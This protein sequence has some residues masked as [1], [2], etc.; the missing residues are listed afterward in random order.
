MRYHGPIMP[1]TGNRSSSPGSGCFA[2]SAHIHYPLDLTQAKRP[3]VRKQPLAANPV[4]GAANMA[5]SVAEGDVRV[6]GLDAQ[7]VGDS[8]RAERGPADCGQASPSHS[9]SA[10]SVSN[11]S[12]AL[13][14]NS[15]WNLNHSTSKLN[16]LFIGHLPIPGIRAI[17]WWLKPSAGR[18]DQVSTTERCGVVAN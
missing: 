1:S 14:S 3:P 9:W 17:H 15:D 18:Y 4:Y 7:T 8:G 10:S 12:T 5:E 6:V 16:L 13:S 11:S 2:P